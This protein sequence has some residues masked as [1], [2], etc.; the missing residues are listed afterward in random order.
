VFG[1]VQEKTS[2]GLEIKAGVF[3]NLVFPQQAVGSLVS[4]RPQI[5]TRVT[6]VDHGWG[7]TVYE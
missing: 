6:G 1:D 7:D 5:G 4:R 2:Y 3:P